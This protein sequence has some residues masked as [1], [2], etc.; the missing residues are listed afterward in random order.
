MR[1]LKFGDDLFVVVLELRL[2]KRV[3]RKKEVVELVVDFKKVELD[4]VR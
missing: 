3:V 4:S 2:D 1:F